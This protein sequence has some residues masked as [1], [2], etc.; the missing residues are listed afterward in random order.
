MITGAVTDVPGGKI[1][2]VV[3]HLEMKA[4]AARRE[5]P[6]PDGVTFRAVEADVTWYRDIFDRVG[7]DWLWFGR[8]TLSDEALMQ[9]IADKDVAL[10]TLTRD[11]VDEA[12]LELDFRQPGECE[13]AYFGLSGALIGTGAGRALMDRAIAHAW[14]RPITRFHVH[15]CTNDSPQALGFYIRSGF[16]PFKRQIEI[17]DDPRLKGLLPEDTAPHLP[18]I[19]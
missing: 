11:G 6:L 2:V 1:A 12:L 14:A 13:L 18:I 17:E 19:R 16:T 5:A 15:T 10:F 8:R 9:I 3:T 7:R 4:R